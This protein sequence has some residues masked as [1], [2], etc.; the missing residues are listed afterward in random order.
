[1][2]A[3]L[4]DTATSFRHAAD[5]SQIGLATRTEA[6]S[7]DIDATGVRVFSSSRP[8]TSSSSRPDRVA[9]LAVTGLSAQ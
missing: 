6:G 8:G 1:L 5:R 2:S 4:T 7:E 3:A 9:W